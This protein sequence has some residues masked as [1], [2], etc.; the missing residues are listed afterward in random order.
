MD[1]LQRVAP[2]VQGDQTG[3]IEQLRGG[4]LSLRENYFV[5]GQVSVIV[6]FGIDAFSFC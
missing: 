3:S 6:F 5:V 1:P 2:E 4:A